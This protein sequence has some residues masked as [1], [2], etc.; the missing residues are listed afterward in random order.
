M[1][2]NKSRSKKRL[3]YSAGSDVQNFMVHLLCIQYFALEWLYLVK[4]PN[5]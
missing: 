1:R 4:G 2:S 5:Q 3:E